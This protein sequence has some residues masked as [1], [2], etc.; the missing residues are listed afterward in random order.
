MADHDD[1][2]QHDD[3][4]D[5]DDD[6]EE[7]DD[8][9]PVSDD[10]DV[11][12]D[13]HLAD[14]IVDDDDTGIPPFLDG[15]L[16]I[17]PSKGLCYEHPGMFCLVCQ[18][19]ISSFQLASPPMDTPLQFAGWVQ[20][21]TEWLEFIITFSKQAASSDPLEEK[22]LQAQEEKNQK[23]RHQQRQPS[24]FATKSS[25]EDADGEKPSS[26]NLKSPPSYAL[27][28]DSKSP[29]RKNVVDNGSCVGGNNLKAPS[30]YSTDGNKKEQ[31][32]EDLIVLSASQLLN[33]DSCNKRKIT[34]RGAYRPSDLNVD[35]LWVISSVQAQESMTNVSSSSSAAG[36]KRYPTAAAAASSRKRRRNTSDDD[37][38]SVDGNGEVEYQEL[39]DLHDDAGLSTEEL[40]RRYYG[41]DATDNAA[42]NDKVDHDDNTKKPFSPTKRTREETEDDDD[43]DDGYGF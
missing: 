43:D 2:F 8:F 28:D 18:T 31:Q 19:T 10:E 26:K 27:D 9:I 6:D 41:G 40:R 30:L 1:K 38:D 35:R 11:D 4:D 20:D 7:E 22:L 13:Y 33:G 39:I 42:T 23:T 5:D 34:F 3:D 32:Q 12:G 25:S 16:F 37:D 36:A 24:S 29:A 15:E 21:P 14:E 17:D